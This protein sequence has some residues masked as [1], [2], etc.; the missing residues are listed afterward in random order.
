VP[1]RDAGPNLRLGRS[2]VVRTGDLGGGIG[3]AV[4]VDARFDPRHPER[5]EHA[6]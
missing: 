1:H 3:A 2:G 6:G 5:G 4:G